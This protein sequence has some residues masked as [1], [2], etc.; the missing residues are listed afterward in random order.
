MSVIKLPAMQMRLAR[1]LLVLSHALAQQDSLAME[2]TVRIS[3]NALPVHAIRM[4][5]APTRREHTHVFAT[6]DTL[7]MARTVKTSMNAVCPRPAT[8]MLLALILRG[9]LLVH[10][11]MDLLEMEPIAKMSMNAILAHVILMRHAPILWDP[12]RALVTSVTLAMGHSVKTS[13]NATDH[14]AT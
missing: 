7:V 14:P 5:H 13:M 3:M 12:T 2:L 8:Q 4:Q 1:I 6:P 10:A 9:H 11:I